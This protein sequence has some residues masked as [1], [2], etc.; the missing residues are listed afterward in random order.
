MKSRIKNVPVKNL[1]VKKVVVDAEIENVL[2]DEETDAV[3]AVLRRVANRGS[4][5]TA[6]FVYHEE[7]ENT[8]YIDQLALNHIVEDLQFGHDLRM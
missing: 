3:S 8:D 4:F 1:K 5:E 6:R 7:L 2:F